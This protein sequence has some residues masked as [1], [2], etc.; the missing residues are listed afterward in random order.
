MTETEPNVERFDA[1]VVGGGPAGSTAARRL[2]QAGARTL[3]LEKAQH[4]RYKACGGGL[5]LRTLR[6]ID[7][8]LDD[9]IEGEVRSIEV[10]HFGKRSFVKECPEPFAYMVMRDRFDHRL[11]E[12]ASDAGADVRQGTAVRALELDSTTARVTTET[13]GYVTQHLLAA[14]GATGPVARWAELGGGIQRSLRTGDPAPEATLQRWSGTANVDAGYQPW[15]Y[16]WVFPKEGRL[17]VGVVLSPGRGNSI[18]LFSRRYVER[19]GLAD[20]TVTTVVG[21]P[22]RYRHGSD[23][24]IARG[25]VLLLGD[26]AGL[27]GEFTAEG[28]AYAVHSG[29][30]AA[31]AVEGATGDAAAAASAFQ[32]SVNRLIQ[33]ELDAARAISRL[34]YRCITAWPALALAVSKRID[35]FWRAFFRV[36]RGEASYDSELNRWPLLNLATR[37]L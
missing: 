13:D 20:T 32:G 9:V 10:S 21:H 2:A 33:P 7:L 31:Q 30:L 22:I 37:V 35:Y 16:G 24:A 3:V 8:P 28:T 19:L 6:H 26:A 36:M 25:P 5:P 1:I 29:V 15:S 17:S 12:A 34:Y 27:A 14:D 18:K 4:P 11:L 23:E